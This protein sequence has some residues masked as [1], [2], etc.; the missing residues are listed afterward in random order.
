MLAFCISCLIS[1]YRFVLIFLD[2][3]LFC[4]FDFFFLQNEHVYISCN[5]FHLLTCGTFSNLSVS[6]WMLLRSQC[7]SLWHSTGN[8]LSTW[9]WPHFPISLLPTCLLILYRCQH[10][11]FNTMGSLPMNQ[12]LWG[13]LSNILWKSNISTRSPLSTFIEACSGIYLSVI[14]SSWNYAESL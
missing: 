14:F 6:L 7:W 5:T 10:I 3:N 1:F 2:L 13:I 11:T 9:K 8:R 12:P 4:C